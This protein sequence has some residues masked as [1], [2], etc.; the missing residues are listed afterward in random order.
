M[1]R[2][3]EWSA[4]QVTMNPDLVYVRTPE[5]ERLARLPRQIPSGQR[6]TLLL[7]DGNITVGELRHRFGATLSIDTALEQ[8][9]RGGLVCVKAGAEVREEPIEPN[10]PE[11]ASALVLDPLFDPAVEHV[12]IEHLGHEVQ[13]EREERLEP[14]VVRAHAALVEAGAHPLPPAAPHPEDPADSL[15]TEAPAPPPRE[16]SS[17][18]DKLGEKARWLG[19]GALAL[20][21]VVVLTS[22]F[23]GLRPKVEARATAALGVPVSVRAIG[24][25]LHNG[26]ALT[27]KDVTIGLDSPLVLPRVALMPDPSHGNVWSPSRVMIAGATLK[28]SELNALASLLAKS[29]AVTELEFEDLSLRLGGRQVGGLAGSLE[30]A[31]GGA[32]VL[33]LGYPAGGLNMEARPSGRGLAIYLT[34]SPGTL[35]LLGG[36]QIGTVELRGLLDDAG[37]SDGQ[38]GMTGYGGKLEGSLN[39]AWDG[40]V[41]LDAKLR[42]AAVSMKQLSRSL[43][44]RGGFAEGQASGMLAV[45]ARAPRWEE[46][47]RIERMTGNFTVERGAF[48]GFDLGAALRE[49]SAGPLSGGETRFD[50]LRGR[51]EAGPREIRLSVENLD[52]GAL[53]A[54]GV[55]TVAGL[56]SLRGNLSAAVQ[57]PGRGVLRYP[58]QLSGTVATPSIQLVLPAGREASSVSVPFGAE[59]EQQ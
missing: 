19:L 39:M 8:L 55:L 12:A 16:R 30:S 2:F 13:A 50:N 45:E 41:S 32:A 5:G 40:R 20:S 18:R 26:P 1:V 10:E 43:F 22:L 7:V 44:Q 21:V 4:I 27:L 15:T 42:I 9:E 34:A 11:D 58:A 24:P 52:A 49:R 14:T 37:F 33:K 46:L 29:A 48:A 25:A 3:G 51:L 57:V 6:A 53:T 23:A 59:R 17:I 31:E 36:P 38:L 28:P 56:D 47:T 54:S 35:P